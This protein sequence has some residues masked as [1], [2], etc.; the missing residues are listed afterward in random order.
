MCIA[1]GGGGQVCCLRLRCWQV[2][3]RDVRAAEGDV[4][5]RVGERAQAAASL[6]GPERGSGRAEGV[7]Q[8]DQ[9][10][11]AETRRRAQHRQG[12]TTTTELN[13]YSI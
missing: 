1:G 11:A 9:E 7:Q 12:A 2:A 3:E 6:H 10:T 5:R 4:H 13:I 8:Q